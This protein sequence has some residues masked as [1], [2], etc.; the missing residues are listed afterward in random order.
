MSN[1]RTAFSIP[2]PS[3]R[4]VTQLMP[5]RKHDKAQNR[6]LF[7]HWKLRSVLGTV[8]GALDSLS[9][10]SNCQLDFWGKRLN[11]P[12][13]MVLRSHTQQ[14]NSRGPRIS[15]ARDREAESGESNAY[16]CFAWLYILDCRCSC[17][18]GTLPVMRWAWCRSGVLRGILCSATH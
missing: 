10:H 11:K 4:P 15:G 14:N 13:L 9:W 6:D 17:V 5:P 16:L 3:S 12:C 1:T 7:Q 2:D 18:E 8:K